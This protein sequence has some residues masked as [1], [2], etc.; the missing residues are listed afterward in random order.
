MDRLMR[1]EKTSKYVEAV[2]AHHYT[3]IIPEHQQNNVN[4]W[5]CSSKICNKRIVTRKSTGNLVCDSLPE[6]DHG[7][8][9]KKQKTMQL[10]NQVVERMAGN[11]S[12]T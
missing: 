10:E 8:N 2:D 5:L 1:F 11:V 6:H 4:Y 12:N 7:N 9:V 3:C